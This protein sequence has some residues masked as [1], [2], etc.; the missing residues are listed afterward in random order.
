M[1]VRIK[2][3][4][5]IFCNF[6]VLISCT[7]KESISS[8]EA[9]L[10]Y[11]KVHELH[12]DINYQTDREKWLELHLQRRQ[13]VSKIKDQHEI[14]L[15]FYHYSGYDFYLFKLYEE[16]LLAYKEFFKYYEKHVNEFSPEVK[17]DFRAKRSFDYR[18]TALA[19]EKLGHLDSAYLEHQN[20]LAL[21]EL[22]DGIWYPAAHNDFGIFLLGSLKDSIAAMQQFEM[23]YKVT[24]EKF[25]DHELIGS[26]R[27]NLGEI[28]LNKGRLEKAFDMFHL[29]Y[30]YYKEN[31][32]NHFSNESHVFHSA[33]KVVEIL[34]RQQKI[35]ILN[36]FY[37]EVKELYQTSIFTENTKCKVKLEFLEVEMHQKLANNNFEKSHQLLADIKILSDSINQA[38]F[39]SKENY[40]IILND[41]VLNG[42]ND[43]HSAEKKQKEVELL[44][45]RLITWL[46]SILSI[47]FLV[48]MSVLYYLRK[49]HIENARNKQLIAQQN[50]ELTSIRNQQLKLEIESKQ[51]DLSDFAI[52]LTQ[53]QEWAKVLASKLEYLKTTRGRERKKLMDDFEN[54]V[55]KKTIF[56]TNTKEFYEKIDKLSDAFYSR[57]HSKFP[58]LSKT[59][60][61]L[62][63]L[64]RLNIDSRNI[65]IVQNI[66]LSSL[67][68]SRY[69]LRKKM[70]L[71]KDEELDDFIQRL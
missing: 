17:E 7:Q 22:R 8:E 24:A 12:R 43:K 48:V 20:N 65:A 31:L 33:A 58:D 11:R 44:N 9:L 59:E 32:K 35:Q 36:D 10:K 38:E 53:N 5:L 67:N 4:C 62:C 16:S 61:R 28:Y 56:D 19:Y 51:R 66:T 71:A 57:L 64:I 21:V 52:N 14:V 42:I 27:N 63:S 41:L 26:I 54:E 18:G 6:L 25:P 55:L 70:N 29:N 13:L 46:I 45:Q 40:Q 37:M 50:L 34:G 30:F 3:L 39:Y 1:D 2:W 68:K 60:K 69:R 49:Q 15:N 47:I 23:V